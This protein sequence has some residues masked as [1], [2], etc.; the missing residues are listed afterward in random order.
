LIENDGSKGVHNPTFARNVL[1]TTI[2]A[3]SK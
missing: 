1:I 2:D 3:I